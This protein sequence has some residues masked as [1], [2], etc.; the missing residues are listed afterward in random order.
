MKRN[1]SLMVL[2]LLFILN[3]VASAQESQFWQQFKQAK[4]DGTEPALPDFSYAGYQYSEQ[5]IPD[6]STWTVFDVTKYG[7]VP[8]D[9]NYDDKAIQSA[10]HAAEKAGGGVVLFPK[11]RFMLSPNETVGENIFITGSNILIKGQGSDG[12]GTEIFMDKMKIDNRRYIFEVKSTAPKQKSVT[13]V[14]ADAA[15]ETFKIEVKSTKKLH[16]GQRILLRS[17]S[18]ELAKSHFAP[19]VLNK[20][21][22]RINDRGFR[23]QE[24]HTVAKIEGN[25]VFLREPLH[26]NLTINKDPIKV[27][28]YPMINHVGFEDLLFKGNWNSYP[29]AFKHHKNKLHDYAWNALRID[30]L[31]NG[32]I[33]NVQFK[34]WNQG[35]FISGSAALT[36]ENLWFSGKK[37]H[38]SVHV[39]KSYGVLVKDSKDTANHHH[40]TGVGYWNSGAVYLRYEMAK[41]QHIDSHS[42]SPYATLFDNVR[43]G[44]LHKN[45]GPIQSYPHHGKYM[46]FW[47]FV[48]SGSPK[49]YDF[50]RTK[51]NGN[52]FAAPFFVGLQGK[53]VTLKKG[54]YSANELQGQHAQPSSLF[55]AQLALR[56]TTK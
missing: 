37:G 23:L 40:G 15:R 33:R 31:E 42:G 50:W 9:N 44:T 35:V 20:E 38:M 36:L 26:L 51:R 27:Q 1:Q 7:A 22:T 25:T 12:N 21:W 3:S 17:N 30:N 53:K 56:L 45:G 52:T 34:D 2:C 8:N 14:V 13:V 43:N 49:K 10:I 47:N 4:S 32:W 29:E 18:V 48:L 24:I 19:L 41:G 6:T 5:P 46:T 16:V 54:T 28:P 11:G 55:E 39:R